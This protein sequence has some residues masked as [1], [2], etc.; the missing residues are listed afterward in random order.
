MRETVFSCGRYPIWR[1]ALEG[2][3]ELRRVRAVA[4][5]AEVVYSRVRRS[6]FRVVAAV[7]R[8]A[9][10]I[11]SGE[12]HSSLLQPELTKRARQPVESVAELELGDLEIVGIL[13]KPVH[14]DIR[15]K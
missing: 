6:G 7:A 2:E 10:E 14:P 9:V 15:R 12:R 5:I 3:R 4:R 8:E 1:A 13:R 11:A